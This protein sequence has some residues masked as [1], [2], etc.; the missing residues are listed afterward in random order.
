MRW[1]EFIVNIGQSVVAEHKDV[2]EF[3]NSK[4][5][6]DYIRTFPQS[7]LY[8]IVSRNATIEEV[9]AIF[10]QNKSLACVI[11]TN[12]GVVA[13]LPIGIITNSDIM[14]LLTIIEKY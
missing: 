5:I 4:T 3:I 12:S 9:L 14:Q 6:E 7:G 1:R 10:G 8:V 13:E 2:D 11:I